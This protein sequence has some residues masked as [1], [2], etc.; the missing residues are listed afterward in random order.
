MAGFWEE[1]ACWE[2]MGLKAIVLHR[3]LRVGYEM[4]S[5]W[6]SSSFCAAPAAGQPLAGVQS[7]SYALLSSSWAGSLGS[8]VSA[9]AVQERFPPLS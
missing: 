6:L 2:L 5:L 1:G 8:C 4:S 3:I 7:R 9:G